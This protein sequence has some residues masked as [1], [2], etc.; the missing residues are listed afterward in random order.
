MS[1]AAEQIT[2]HSSELQSI[3][4]TEEDLT[5]VRLELQQVSKLQKLQRS[6]KVFDTN[7][8]LIA[9]KMNKRS[10]SYMINLAL[11][12]DQ[13]AR[14]R[15][16][17][18]KL[19]ISAAIFGVAAF[20]VLHL[21]LKGVPWL[22]N[23]YSYAVIL[24]LAFGS[25]LS[26]Y[27]TIR[28]FKNIWVFYSMR[29]RIPIIVLYHHL[30][31]KAQFMKFI[32]GMVN[33]IAKAKQALRIPPSQLVPLEVGEHRRLNDEGIISQKQYEVAKNRILHK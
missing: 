20:L 16:I 22:S 31:D 1:V 6:V 10:R 9:D 30:P 8:A 27:L 11:L 19:L 29:G 28:S 13:P 14:I 32:D 5:T 18:W 4:P 25:L 26:V 15:K 17:N 7:V 3:T 12:G 33:S 24:S 23:E 21:K 2:L